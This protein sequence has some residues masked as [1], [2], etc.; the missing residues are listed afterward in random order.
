VDP[1]LVVRAK[2]GDQEAFAA[3][4]AESLGR[5]NAVARLILRDPDAADDAVQDALVAAWRGLRALREPDRFGGWLNRLLV[6]ACYDRAR[7]ERRRRVAEVRVTPIVEPSASDAQAS[8]AM[9][10]LFERSLERMP[11]DQRAAIVAVYYLDLSI[12]EAAAMVGI[13]VGTMKSRL[14]RS[15]QSLHAIVDA[16]ERGAVAGRESVA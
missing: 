9:H 1:K 11:V 10:D 5:L 16:D 15:L 4:A 14:H 2:A 12:P 8:T 7:R 3:L 6:R 13:P